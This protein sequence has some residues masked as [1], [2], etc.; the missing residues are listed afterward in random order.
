MLAVNL[1]LVST[2]TQTIQSSPQKNDFYTGSSSFLDLLRSADEELKSEEKSQVSDRKISDKEE[3]SS[4]QNDGSLN[5]AVAEQSKTDEVQKTE[6]PAAKNEAETQ[7]VAEA[8]PE[9]SLDEIRWLKTP[10]LKGGAEA[11]ENSEVSSEDF[12][13]LIDGAVEFIPGELSEQEKLEKAQN[14]SFNDPELFLEKSQ[15]QTA[16]QTAGLESLQNPAEI[17]ENLTAT[18]SKRPDFAELSADLQKE[19]INSQKEEK[20]TVKIEV[21]D[22]RTQKIENPAELQVQKS[23]QR[24]D[25]NLS[26]RRENENTVQVTLDLASQVNQ[27]ITASS[28][29]S[30]SANGSTF[31]SMLSNAVRQNAA[32]F[33]KAGNV[34]LKDNNQGSINLIVHPEKLGNVKISLNLSD[35][36]ISGSITVHSQEAYEALKDSIASLKNAFAGGGFETGEFNL[37]FSDQSQQFAQSNGGQDSSAQKEFFA[38]RAYGDYSA[39]GGVLVAENVQAQ[40]ADSAYSV[41]IVA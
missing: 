35:K 4:A 16:E 13:S 33:V 14:L 41:N 25:F 30:A 39:E 15:K 6:A 32:D 7:K 5:V 10:V 11:N 9:V 12:A 24:K 22:L 40:T 20:N 37:N 19:K 36:V 34:V 3:D 18:E 28:D 26:Y 38:G 8:G 17:A 21:T 27:N 2:Q 23:Q 31:Q 29:Q 1:D